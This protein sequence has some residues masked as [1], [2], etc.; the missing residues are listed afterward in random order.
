[1]DCFNGPKVLRRYCDS[2]NTVVTGIAMCWT[3]MAAA[4]TVS[5][6]QPPRED[7]TRQGQ[8]T[9]GSG[10]ITDFLP[11]NMAKIEELKA[12]VD[13]LEPLYAEF[14]K[15]RAALSHRCEALF[16]HGP[17][18]RDPIGK[19]WEALRLYELDAQIAEIRRRIGEA[20]PAPKSGQ[21]GEERASDLSTMLDW[22]NKQIF[23]LQNTTKSFMGIIKGELIHQP[24]FNRSECEAL[25]VE[26]EIIGD[27]PGTYGWVLSKEE[28]VKRYCDG[29][30]QLRQKLARHDYAFSLAWIKSQETWSFAMLHDAVRSYDFWY[31]LATDRGRYGTSAYFRPLDVA[32]YPKNSP[33]TRELWE[34]FRRFVFGEYFDVPAGQEVLSDNTPIVNDVNDEMA[35][36]MRDISPI[37]GQPLIDIFERQEFGGPTSPGYAAPSTTVLLQPHLSGRPA[38]ITLATIQALSSGHDPLSGRLSPEADFAAKWLGYYFLT[39]DE[40]AS[41]GAV[42]QSASPAVPIAA[43]KAGDETPPPVRADTPPPVRSDSETTLIT[44]AWLRAFVD[45]GTE[46]LS[47]CDAA[48]QA[49][50]KWEK[51]I[52]PLLTN[53]DGKYIAADKNAIR[54]FRA[55]YSQS[56]PSGKEIQT[57]RTST[58]ALIAPAQKALADDGSL[59]RPSDDAA[60]LLEGYKTQLQALL[61][62]YSEHHAALFAIASAA[63]RNSAPASITLQEATTELEAHEA[64][65]RA[66]AVAVAAESAR[67]D[68]NKKLA[69]A[70]A[71]KTAQAAANE[72]LRIRTETESGRVAAENAAQKSRNDDDLAKRLAR[73]RSVE[74]QSRLKPFFAK[75]YWQPGDKKGRGIDSKAM[76]LA[77]VRKWGALEASPQGLQK[78][79]SLGCGKG[80][81]GSKNGNDRSVLW[82]YPSNLNRLTP[83]QLEELKKAQRDLIEL[84]EAFVELSLM[85]P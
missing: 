78:C 30:E 13:E 9:T 24:A 15:N 82:G 25:A 7:A 42:R 2:R 79:L 38:P 48:T 32:A 27:G 26:A 64:G 67:K 4:T 83:D 14:K 37:P 73:A 50:S 44:R 76:S 72:E 66:Q 46:V 69:D 51:E 12:A 17:Y 68:A 53:S 34:E 58:E 47:A 77:A 60:T 56:R 6:L 61:T 71:A 55:T 81:G 54:A 36:F 39:H 22:T 75:G 5:A 28:K 65:E 20:A 57:I 40:A 21:K 29:Q 18:R 63:K 43:T 74:V 49:V 41:F 16:V 80:P 33:D 70:E 23:H 8:G 35:R 62:A 11:W 1:M 85:E 45:K 3:F 31:A 84:G 59:Y 10:P 19:M 52:T